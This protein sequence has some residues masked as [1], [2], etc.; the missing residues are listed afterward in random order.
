MGFH[1]VGGQLLH[2]RLAGRDG[3]PRLVLV[4][5]LGTDARIWDEVIALLE[6]RYQILSFDKRGHGLSDAPPAPYTLADHVGD[7][8]GL[9]DHIGWQRFALAG[10]SVGGLIAQ[11][12]A[13]AHP[14]RLAA[15]VLLDTAARIGDDASWDA[16]IS[17]VQD[18]GMAAIIDMVMQRWFT[19][20]YFATR[21]DDAAGWRHLLARTPADGYIGT[22]TTLRDT[23]LRDAVSTITLR[24]LVAVGA[25]DLSTTPELVRE[26][27]DRLPDARFE[28]IKGA[29]HLPCLDQPQALAALMQDYFNEVCFV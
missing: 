12:F 23:D 8:E 15:L 7:I 25:E 10:V 20:D 6:P 29:G 21:T 1:R 16:R 5:S 17:A 26:T 3:A 9:T 4:N 2:Y 22:C 11:G 14:E 27:A 13:L 28:T 24:T 18:G 19:K